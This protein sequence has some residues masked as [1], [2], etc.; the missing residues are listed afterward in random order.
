[1]FQF[2][3]SKQRNGYFEEVQN[4]LKL[5]FPDAAARILA[6]SIDNCHMLIKNITAARAM[7]SLPAKISPASIPQNICFSDF[8]T[9]K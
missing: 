1:M 7:A 5:I 2:I 3:I 9:D 8:Q 6:V 4:N